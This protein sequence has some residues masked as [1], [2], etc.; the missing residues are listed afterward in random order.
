MAWCLYY[1]Q[2]ALFV[3][4]SEAVLATNVGRRNFRPGHTAIIRPLRDSIDHRAA[5]IYLPPPG[6][7]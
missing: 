6:F 2:R 7:I 5:L 1:A 4:M 3:V